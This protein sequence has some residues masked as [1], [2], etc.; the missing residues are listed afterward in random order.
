MH[1][2]IFYSS[3]PSAQARGIGT[4]PLAW[5]MPL[6]QLRLLVIAPIPLVRL[7]PDLESGRAALTLT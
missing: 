1:G 7:Q 5:F 3:K 2:S 6:P 4:I